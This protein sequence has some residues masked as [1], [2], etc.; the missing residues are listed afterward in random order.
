MTRE[1]NFQRRSIRLKHYDYAEAGAYF[2]TV[3][4]RN[5]ECMFGTIMNGTVQ[6][7]ELG[8]VVQLQWLR[9]AQIRNNIALDQFV[10]MPNHLHG[11]INILRRGV[12]PCAPV[13]TRRLK[14]PSQ[15]LGAIIRGFK[16]STTKHINVMRNT[17]GRPVWQDNFYEH[18]IRNEDDLNAIR[19]YILNNP[20][21]WEL[22]EENPVN[23]R[24]DRPT[25]P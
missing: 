14:S 20:L 23:C 8:N 9:T 15:T 1:L 22:D 2:V 18:V 25:F 13:H 6:L 3:C 7:H 5:R 12:L 11:I 4:S 16:S 21:Q 24:G 17:P 10:V 19:D